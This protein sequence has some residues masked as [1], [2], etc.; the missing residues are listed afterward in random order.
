MPTEWPPMAR[1]GS[2]VTED[3]V[4]AFEAKLGA[5]LPDDYRTFLLEVNGGRTAKSHRTFPVDGDAS[6]LNSLV[7]L[8][9]PDDARDLAERNKLIRDDLPPDLLLVGSDDGGARI[10]LCIR[11][12]HRGEV[13][14]FDTNDA[15]AEGAN[16]RV[17]WH[18]RRDLAKLA[19]SFRTFMSSLT[20]L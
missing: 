2:A 1:S 14:Y 6:I 8:N 5:T 10:C 13:W 9:D 12:P 4:R 17:L 18:D 16:P 19:D 20:P 3:E 7:S 15:R 11:G